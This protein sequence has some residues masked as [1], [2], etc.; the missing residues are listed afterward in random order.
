M[1]FGIKREAYESLLDELKRA[2]EICAQ[3]QAERDKLF[4]ENKRLIKAFE[5]LRDDRYGY[6]N[7][8]K[9]AQQTLDAKGENV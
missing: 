5:K 3:I 9:F 4:E 2:E 6:F 1:N 7:P 8:Q